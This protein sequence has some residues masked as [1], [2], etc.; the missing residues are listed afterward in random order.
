[1]AAQHLPNPKPLTPFQRRVYDALL[2][3]PRGHVT[4]YGFLAR[5]VRCGSAQAVGQALRHNPYAPQVPC[6]RVIAADLSLGGFCGAR[7][8]AEIRRKRRLLAS[9]GVMFTADGRLREAWRVFAF[10]KD[11]R[12]R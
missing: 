11:V 5:E 7:T 2:R 1:M 9:E 4:T 3:V 8:G 6:H 12:P 10:G